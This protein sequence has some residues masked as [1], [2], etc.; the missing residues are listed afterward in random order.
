MFSQK[1]KRVICAVVAVAMVVPLA[2]SIVY[3]FI[4]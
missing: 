2:I 4:Q 3:M 1:Q